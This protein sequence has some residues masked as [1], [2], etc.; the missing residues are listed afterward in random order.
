MS[1]LQEIADELGVTLRTVQ[2]RCERG[3]IPGAYRTSK[4]RH[5]EIDMDVWREINR[6]TKDPAIRR[7]MMKGKLAFEF[8]SVM[9]QISDDDKNESPKSLK[10]REPEKYRYIYEK[11]YRDHRKAYEAIQRGGPRGRKHTTL[12]MLMMK[13]EK[14][15][16]NYRDVTVE[17]LARELRMSPR[18]LR[19]HFSLDEIHRACGVDDVEVCGQ[20]GRKVTTRAS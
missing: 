16:L 17:P 11:P 10:E 9:N 18:T 14:L 2:R 19:R 20:R 12:G 15:R 13:A 5:W 7:S 1:F 8:T 4:G 3:L 6:L